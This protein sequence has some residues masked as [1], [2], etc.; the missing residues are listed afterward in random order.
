MYREK[1]SL[2]SDSLKLSRVSFSLFNKTCQK[3]IAGTRKTQDR[4][5]NADSRNWKL[6]TSCKMGNQ[7]SRGIGWKRFVTFKTSF[8]I[9]NTKQ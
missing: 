9:S 7:T 5:F 3:T 6:D 4:N 8:I 2:S 1:S